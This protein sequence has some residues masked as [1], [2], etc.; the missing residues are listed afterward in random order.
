LSLTTGVWNTAL[1]GQALFNNTTGGLNTAVGLNA[2]FQNTTGSDNT[3][4][5]FE[6]LFAN[7]TG[8]QNTATG[9]RALFENTTGF[10]NTANGFQALLF[11]TTG[12]HNTA[13]GDDAL[14][15]NTTGSFNTADGAHSLE[16]NTTG[17]SNV[18]VGFQAGA[19][20]TTGIDN[21]DIGNAG[22][23]DESR[24]IRIGTQGAETRTFIAGVSGSAVTGLAV[25]V[26]SAGQLGTAP[27]SQRFKEAIKP[28]GKASEAILA[29][30]PVSFR[31]KEEVDP[32]GIPQFGLVA[33]E[34]EKIDPDL[35]TR[36]QQGK[37]YTVR[38]EAVNMML[39]NEFLKEHETV[40]KQKADITELK[41]LAEMQQKEI[42]ALTTGLREST[43]ADKQLV[44]N[45]SP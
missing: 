13:D 27:S 10:H 28:M 1:G 34:V 8:F 11:T 3:A 7:T 24:T 33:E 43:D 14:A 36:D 19:N 9:W 41:R 39:L 21:I 44:A 30:K 32:A 22:I 42:V 35:V 40:E 2:L 12:N 38:Y 31:Y 16:S 4:T 25:M 6:A 17:S 37:T 5:G 20:L 29:L 45:S 26:N 15:R 23:A 18:A